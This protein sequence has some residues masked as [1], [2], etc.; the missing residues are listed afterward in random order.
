M[1]RSAT[2]HEQ[3]QRAFPATGVASGREARQRRRG[4][5]PGAGRERV[6][7]NAPPPRGVGE[8]RWRLLVRHAA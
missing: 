2:L 3:P 6:T 8:P 4:A 5:R 7:R 1:G